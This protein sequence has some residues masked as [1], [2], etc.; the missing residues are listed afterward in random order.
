[1]KIST[2]IPSVYSQQAITATRSVQHNGSTQM[3]QAQVNGDRVDISSQAQEIQRAIESVKQLPDVDL[4][5]V[6]KIRSMIENGTY[7]IDSRKIASRMVDEALLN[8]Q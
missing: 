5:K 6:A 2:T 7:S 8:E 1:M 3:G 4:D